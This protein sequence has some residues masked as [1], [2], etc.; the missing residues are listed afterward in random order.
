MQQLII[1]TRG[2]ALALWQANHIKERLQTQYPQMK[3]EI[4][5]VK[6]KG[7]KIL[8]VPLA[9]IGGKGLFTKELEELLLQG[10]IDLAVHSLKD[11]PVE[12]VEGLGLAAITKREDVRDSFL[13][14]KYVSLEELPQGARV[15]TTSLRRVMQ[16]SALRADLDMQS[17]RGN[18]QTRLRRLRE[19][20]FDAIILA[21]A[22]VN[23]LGISEE[24]PYIIPLDFMIPAMG[25]AALGVECKKGS[26]AE[27][28]LQFL[29]DS[30]AAFETACERAFVR[31]LNGGCQV[32]IGVNAALENGILKVRAI[33]GLPNGTEILRECLEVQVQTLIDCERIG[34][35][36]AQ[37]FLRQG[38]EKILQKAQNWEFD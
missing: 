36:M 25:Q 32:P 33:L 38:A 12:F 22:G 1:G 17:L 24:V 26:E 31:T 37:E 28:L 2:S 7:D 6:T 10:E 13:S 21:Q 19:G 34:V 14:F 11:V 4:K 5:I 16:L 35:Q 27:S 8:D 20:D 23:R 9:K 30:K 29:N 18:V 15:G 3:V